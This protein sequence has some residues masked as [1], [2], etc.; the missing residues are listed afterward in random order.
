MFDRLPAAGIADA[1]IAEAVAEDEEPV[2]TLLGVRQRAELTG[3]VLTDA[4]PSFDPFTNA[5]KVSLT[6]NNEGSQ[7]WSQ[8]TGANVG[9]PVA[10][11]LDDVVYTYPTIRGRIPGRIPGGGRGYRIR[12]ERTSWRIRWERIPEGLVRGARTGRPGRMWP[13]VLQVRPVRVSQWR[14]LLHP[15][16]SVFPDA[17][18]ANGA[19]ASRPAAAAGRA[20]AVP[21][22]RHGSRP[23]RGAPDPRCTRHVRPGD[24]RR[25]S[26]R[27]P[28]R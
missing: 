2:F 7:R 25:R 19:W 5:P 23:R 12:S 14:T 6:M 17:G 11:V 9:K 3:E 16:I 28:L 4:R 8:I 24:L 18:R 21:A 13:H 20:A 27:G 22:R 15:G 26:R 1:V 10:V